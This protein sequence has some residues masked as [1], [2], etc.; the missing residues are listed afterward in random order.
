MFTHRDGIKQLVNQSILYALAERFEREVANRDTLS[1]FDSDKERA[2]ASIDGL[3]A[4]KREIFDVLVKK[5][6]PFSDALNQLKK[7][8]ASNASLDRYFDCGIEAESGKVYACLVYAFKSCAVSLTPH[9]SKIFLDEDMMVS[10][11]L[12]KMYAHGSIEGDDAIVLSIVRGM[13]RQATLGRHV[14]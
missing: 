4:A 3:S 10:A 6:A 14:T 7:R 2:R 12:E 11:N 1:K 5:M 9:V 8:T 13:A